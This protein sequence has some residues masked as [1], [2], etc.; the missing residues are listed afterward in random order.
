MA[1]AMDALARAITCHQAGD[2]NVAEKAYL[3]I[4]ADHP[5]HADALHLLG[6]VFYQKGDAA[7]A[8]AHIRRAIGIDP[9]AAMYHANLG[10]VLM[11]QGR[12]AEAAE[13]YR[14]AVAL[15]P[16]DAAVHS[17]MAA[18]LVTAGDFD[19][20]RSR[21][22]LALE[23]APDLAPAHLNLGLALQG[24]GASAAVGAEACFR[25][26]AACD[27]NLADA[28]QALGQLHQGRGEDDAAMECY[29]QAIRAN[30]G[31]AEA[32]CN[33]GNILRERLD[34]SAAMA[35]YDAGLAAAP[36]T[37]ALHANKGVA[38]HELGCFDDALA[39]YER[40][41][42]L[43]SDDAECRRNRA[44]TLLLLGRFAEG[45][46]AYEARWRTARFK[47][48]DR[49]GKAPRWTAAGAK[50]GARVL[51][52]A[53]QGL[54]DTLQ[55]ARYAALLA[56]AGQHVT[57]ECPAA[58][59]RL[60][61]SLDG[62]LQVVEQGAGTPPPSHD[63]QIPLMSLPGVFETDLTTV[64]ADVPYLQASAQ[65]CAAWRRR[66]EKQAGPR[67]GIVWKG[68]PDHPRDRVRS[69]GL[70]PLLPLFDLPGATFISLQKDGATDLAAHG[71][72]AVVD[73]TGD[74]GDFAAT[75]ALVECL[76]LVVTCDTAVGH[77]AGALGRPVAMLLPHVPE[78]RWLLGRDDTPWYPTMRLFRQ[79]ATGDW[80][81]AVDALATY[82]RRHWL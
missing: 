35:Q 64:P 81:G 67:I 50:P 29:R 39:S 82:I 42:A 3:A 61:A 78:W 65:D 73:M 57:L 15:A 55:F 26:A 6:L 69:P 76:D 34:L 1:E 25:R 46:P 10:R 2:L 56:A 27:P 45:W 19:A 79:P 48:Q 80:A 12:A 51:V 37:A 77:L 32:H 16:N 8:M 72:A 30:P 40:A 20:A 75:A 18:A 62:V 54:G 47:G 44:M 11:A 68:S 49:G 33:L 7:T 43:D 70:G 21:A 53:E 23:L 74:L 41:L 38:L 5:D 22:R 59:V 28:H 66:L 52:R 14:E 24:G 58:L 31:M 9:R 63:F 13:A 60:M 4:L 36:D 71:A 17:D